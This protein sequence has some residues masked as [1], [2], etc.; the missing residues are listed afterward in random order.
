M[1]SRVFTQEANKQICSKPQQPSLVELQLQKSIEERKKI[2]AL[3][4]KINRLNSHIFS[5]DHRPSNLKS[6]DLHQLHEKV[7]AINLLRP[8]NTEKL[9]LRQ[10][11]RFQAAVELGEILRRALRPSAFVRARH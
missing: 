6:V 5:K 11:R 4:R 2:D 3:V 8:H 7:Q 9:P 1:S 10:R